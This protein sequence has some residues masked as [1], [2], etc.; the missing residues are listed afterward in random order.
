MKQASHSELRHRILTALNQE[1]ASSVTALAQRLGALRS[2]VSRASNSLLDA[3]LITRKGHTLILSEAGQEELQ[4]LDVALSSR[5]RKTTDS[6]TRILAQTIPIGKQMEALINSPGMRGI[7]AF[8]TSL[9]RQ[10]WK[11]LGSGIMQQ[12]EQIQGIGN[13]LS[14][15][16][17][18]SSG[19]Q[20]AEQVRDIGNALSTLGAVG[21][22]IMQQ[23]EQVQGIGNALST[24]GAAGSGI[25]QALNALDRSYV[26]HSLEA[27]NVTA[28]IQA[29][30]LDLLRNWDQ[31]LS[32][33]LNHL[34]LENNAFLSGI[35]VD[36]EAIARVGAMVDHTVESLI[37][38]TA[39]T[40]VAYHTYFEDTVNGFSQNLALESLGKSLT[41]PTTTVAALVGS[42]RS[43]I[44]SHVI[45]PTEDKVNETTR[46]SVYTA[47]YVAIA[48]RLE[49]YLRPLGEHFIDKWEGAWQTLY[50]ESKDRYSQA[51]HSARELLMQILAHLAPDD[52]F[53]KE[54][55]INHNGKPTRKM[56]VKYILGYDSQSTIELIDDMANMLDSMYN[57]LVGET[58]R[59]DGR[60]KHED[61][62]AALLAAL[63][64]VLTMILSMRSNKQS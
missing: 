24:L 28:H 62:I 34:I 53:S 29:I 42:A 19:I 33:N 61:T 35:M 32:G 45:S 64:G 63:G 25:Q 58:H 18:F 30:N 8:D 7:L 26:Q 57:M 54:D 49:G 4:R 2:S 46:V 13:A 38:Q 22:G 3:G 14:T 59:R 39:W 5:I 56:R 10:T 6:A 47:Q 41:I 44:E 60:H 40:T 48:A 52:A 9:S 36:L 43:I 21:S 17:A 23:A 16:G 27:I 31:G 12:A 51:T 15:L 20:Q 50:S 55:Y 37:N 11:A 1:P